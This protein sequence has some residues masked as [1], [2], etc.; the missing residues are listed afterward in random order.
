VINF[1]QRLKIFIGYNEAG[2]SNII[3]ALSLLDKN[4]KN[5]SDDDI[6]DSYS[7]EDNNENAYVNFIFEFNEIEINKI[8]QDFLK[9]ALVKN[10][11]DIQTL[12]NFFKINKQIFYCID[13]KRKNK[14]YSYWTI[15]KTKYPALECQI[16]LLVNADQYVAKVDNN[17]TPLKNYKYILID[18][19]VEIDESLTADAGFE[20]IINI[21][22][23]VKKEL[24]IKLHPEVIFWSY[25]TFQNIPQ[26][27]NIAS[28]ADNPNS[29]A[30][31]RNMFILS[32]YDEIK[33]EIQNA[34][35]K[36]NGLTNLL[37]RISKTT[38]DYIHSVWP[39]QEMI[40]V[41][42]NEN[43]D[44]IEFGIEDEKNLYEFS[45][46]SDG[47]KRFVSFLLS[48]G[49]QNKTSA[50]ENIILLIDEPD[51]GLHPSGSRY[52]MNELINISKKNYLFYTTHSVFMINKEDIS[53]HYIVK[54]RNEI[55]EISNVDNSNILD[56]EI[57]YNALG[58]SVFEILKK[59]NIIFEGWRDKKMFEMGL[60]Y[61]ED[62]DRINELSSKTGFC[63]SQGVKDIH[64]VTAML[65]L[66]KRN[67]VIIS[68]SDESAKEARKKSNEKDRWLTYNDFD[69]EII[70]CEDFLKL[71][72]NNSCFID[73][74]KQHGITMVFEEKIQ[75]KNIIY[76]Y[77][78]E[79]TKK[80]I[81]KDIQ[82]EILNDYK[83]QLYNNVTSEN[84]EGSYFKFI[85]RLLI[86]L[87]KHE[88]KAD[89]QEI[90][91]A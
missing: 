88:N 87:E 48:I 23:E 90:N 4:N 65:D 89:A 22:L 80:K 9:K 19:Q 29:C 37:R 33:N 16:K 78:K 14:Y 55:T 12:I 70:T 28:F 86:S 44:N 42:L 81:E 85:E 82:K 66:V 59:N 74:C 68:D 41:A 20:E 7:D 17:N 11:N 36:K 43:G 69:S 45:R 21:F 91:N 35:K 75:P 47:F 31:L 63:Y 54:K 10:E 76:Q 67:Y 72:Y 5:I 58:Y 60:K 79:L 77:S 6:R 38:T 32:N 50:M 18:E 25:D 30:V 64:R 24:A 53:S 27:I 84:I 49:A 52:L 51:I 57:I 62:K 83:N 46:R 13:L 61:L 1:N 15:P 8:G 40:K 3:K 56:E 26:K 71:E 2:K 73:A 39:E 34:A